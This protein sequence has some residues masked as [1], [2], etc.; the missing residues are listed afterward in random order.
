MIKC[1]IFDSGF[2]H[3]Y[4][5]C[6]KWKPKYIEW[7][8]G[9]DYYDKCFFTDIDIPKAEY[10]NCKEKIAI[11]SE[12]PDINKTLQSVDYFEYLKLNHNKFDYILTP[13]KDMISL[14]FKKFLYYHQS[15]PWIPKEDQKI[16]IK[17][18]LVSMVASSKTT[19]FG[20]KLRH[21][22]IQ[23]YQQKFLFD[24]YG[25]GYMPFKEHKTEFLK[26]YYYS[27]CVMNSNI[28]GYFTE[29]LGD[30]FATGTIPI[31]W[32]TKSVVDVFN[33]D[34]M[35]FFER[36]EDL[37]EILSSIDE[38]YYYSKMKAIEE[39]FNIATQYTTHEDF[40]YEKYPFIF[41]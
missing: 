11:V 6:W 9:D 20:H 8:R 16:Y 14:D 38:K 30:C 41:I 34:G 24:V 22:I 19:T 39:N 12:P 4:G 15:F 37:N 18:K 31:F 1:K 26:D 28:N 7:Y 3:A 10:I 17:N 25:C 40:I 21:K 23:T 13:Y 29:A 2:A 33:T 35:I 5:M 32:G 36:L 27:I